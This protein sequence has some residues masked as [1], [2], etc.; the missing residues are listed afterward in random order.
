MSAAK[1]FA[2]VRTFRMAAR[3]AGYRFY[4]G[5]AHPGV[6]CHPTVRFGRGVTVRAFAGARIE[7]GAHCEVLDYAWLQA[8]GGTLAIGEHCLIGRGAV[9]FCAE[10]IEIGAGTMTAEY[11]TIRDQDHAHTGDGRLETQGHVSAPIRIGH[12]VWLGAKVTV[13][14]GVDI[15]PHAVVGANAVVTQSLP[16]RAVYGGVPA[17]LLAPA[18]SSES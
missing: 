17:R 15:A 4:L 16:E 8:L 7:I 9:V 6:R 12:D 2:A 11:V 10:S 13:T 18:R 5:L 1:I 3:S 14:K